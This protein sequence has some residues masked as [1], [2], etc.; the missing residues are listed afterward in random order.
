MKIDKKT[1]DHQLEEYRQQ[2]IKANK[3]RQSLFRDYDRSTIITNI[4]DPHA[5]IGD[6]DSGGIF[7]EIGNVWGSAKQTMSDLWNSINYDMD[8]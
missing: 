1:I 4:D 5:G 3:N 2:Q 8:K 6:N 7:D